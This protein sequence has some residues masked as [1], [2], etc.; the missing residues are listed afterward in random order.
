MKIH[1][2][3]QVK[4][5]LDPER[6]LSLTLNFDISAPLTSESLRLSLGHAEDEHSRTSI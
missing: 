5:V 1:L 6:L 4:S 3:T 2:T